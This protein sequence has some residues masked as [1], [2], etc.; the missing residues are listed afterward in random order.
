MHNIHIPL[1]MEYRTD[2]KNTIIDD[3]TIRYCEIYRITNRIN[4]KVYI[5]QAVSHI[6]NH[7]RFRPYGMEARFRSHISEAF[8][9][10]KCQCHYLNNAIRKYGTENFTLQLLKY[11]SVENADTIETEEIIA[12]NSLFPNGYNLNTGGKSSRHTDESR[13]R[14]SNG[15]I[16]HFKEQ[17]LQRF[18][19]VK[20]LDDD[21]EKYVR[22]L[23]RFNVQY[24]WYVLINRK[25]ADF[26]GACITLEE[27][28]KMA[29]DFILKIKENSTL[30]QHNQIAGNSLETSQTTSLLETTDEGTR[31]MT[32]PNGKTGE[33]LD[34]PQPSP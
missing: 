22:P 30:V 28:K 23:N 13:K 7:K 18:K 6:L 25:K 14:V 12:N 4:Q 19:D 8:S 3:E 11:C 5:G 17:K 16:N 27:S 33:V 29:F 31:V 21:F 10:K 24:G 15:V 1:E 26:G 32:D 20:I 2:L 9:D 34:N